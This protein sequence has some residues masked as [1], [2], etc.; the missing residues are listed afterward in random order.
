MRMRG[1]TC[2]SQHH[3]PAITR[4]RGVVP[5]NSTPCSPEYTRASVNKELNGFLR[6]RRRLLSI[7]T[8][9]FACTQFLLL[10][11]DG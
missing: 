3:S 1:D 10:T 5:L 11:S 7:L 2:I 4:F 9:E 6:Q 8:T